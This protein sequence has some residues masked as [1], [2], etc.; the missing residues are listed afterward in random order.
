MVVVIV[1]AAIVVIIGLWAMLTYNSLVSLRN[2]SEEA[3]SGIDVQLKR[4]HDLIPNLVETVK[5]YAAHEANVLEAVSEYNRARSIADEARDVP[6]DVGL[7]ANRDILRAI[8]LQAEIGSKAGLTLNAVDGDGDDLDVTTPPERSD[9]EGDD[10]PADPKG[11]DSSSDELRSLER[12]LQTYYQRIQDGLDD[13]TLQTLYRQALA[14]LV[15]MQQASVRGLAHYD[16]SRLLTEL[17]LFPAWYV[18]RHHGVTVAH[19]ETV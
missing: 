8:E 17:E 6:A 11:R 10:Q 7:L 15:R 5:G 4:R 3:W 13:A 19:L 9:E 2:R 12:R 16:G 1:I 18:A 14:A